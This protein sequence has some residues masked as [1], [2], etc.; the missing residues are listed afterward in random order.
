MG[1]DGESG[2]YSANINVLAHAGQYFWRT[3]EATVTRSDEIKKRLEAAYQWAKDCGNEN[4]S[5][6]MYDY[7]LVGPDLAYLLG[8]LEQAREQVGRAR[9]AL[10]SMLPKW[11]GPPYCSDM[12][13]FF[14][15]RDAALTYLTAP[16]VKPSS[17]ALPD[18]GE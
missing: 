4:L 16:A 13:R 9:W 1:R 2:V 10:E 12:V 5:E 3:M 14:D 18:K 15:I 17:P 7:K 8:E 11:C 6:G